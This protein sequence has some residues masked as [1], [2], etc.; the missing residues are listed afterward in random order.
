MT[1]DVNPNG[2]MLA[3][4]SSSSTYVCAQVSHNRQDC[5]A[6]A[7]HQ[8]AL[9]QPPVALGGAARLLYR[10]NQRLTYALG[11]GPAT[12]TNV[13]ST[14]RVIPQELR[15]MAL[16]REFDEEMVLNMFADRF[17]QQSFNPVM[18]WWKREPPP[19]R[20]C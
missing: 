12:F 7:G 4:H 19:T 11:D 13:G 18:C 5:S 1:E 2:Q 9:D 8:L 20:L 15:E 6:Y 14:I 16:L 17:V 3:E 10:V